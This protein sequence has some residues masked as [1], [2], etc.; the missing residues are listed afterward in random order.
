MKQ[1][2]F[3]DVIYTKYIEVEVPDNHAGEDAE[4]INKAVDAELGKLESST[5]GWYICEAN[6]GDA[7]WEV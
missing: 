7:T 5:D 3:I 1:K 2:V 6:W 4:I